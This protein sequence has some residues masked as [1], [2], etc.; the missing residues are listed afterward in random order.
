MSRQT[1][2]IES[3]ADFDAHI[4]HTPQLNGW[5]VQGVDLTE[6]TEQ[7][8][9]VDPTGAV[10]LGCTLATDEANDLRARGAFLFPRLPDL[11]FD[12]YRTSLYSALELYGDGNYTAG[13]DATVYAWT[14]EHQ[15]PH[16]L[17]D[18]LAMA[19]HD[20]SVT[21]ALDEATEHVPREHVIGV[22]GGHSLS[23]TD[24]GFHDAARLGLRL[25][26]AGRT[27]LTGGGPGAME[28]ANLGAWFAGAPDAF[29]EA[30]GLL[31]TVPSFRPSLDEWA[32]VAL[33]VRDLCPEQAAGHS[34]GVPTWFYGHEPP[35]VFATEIAK[36]FTN[37]LRED[38]LLA[39]CRGGIIY[40][41]GRAGTVQEIFQA[42]TE[43]YYA[44]DDTVIAPMILV[45]VDYWTEHFPAWQ[46]LQS[47]G[48][49]RAMGQSI[50]CVDTVD[51]AADIL[52]S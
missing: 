31:A 52:L 50:A 5:I 4:D 18:T 32:A 35:N 40:L 20:H 16:R 26:L 36:Y 21:D 1:L 22:M 7:L 23:R 43:N 45:G 28:A 51:E 15:V 14:K 12:P 42:V 49:D 13:V 8:A 33:R 41:P 47:L 11:P 48:R 25:T 10:F 39:R 9:G 3:L 29:D 44:A 6:R 17:Q 2:E 27:V 24:P 19:L 30:V 38:T 46:L 34:I 37:A